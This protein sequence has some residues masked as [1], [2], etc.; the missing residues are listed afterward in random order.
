MKGEIINHPYRHY[1]QGHS[2]SYFQT[3]NLILA[4]IMLPRSL[5]WCFVE[6]ETECKAACAVHVNKIY[7]TG[8]PFPW[9]SWDFPNWEWS[10]DNLRCIALGIRPIWRINSLTLHPLLIYDIPQDSHQLSTCKPG[11]SGCLVRDLYYTKHFL[12]DHS[13]PPRGDDG[14]SF[15][16]VTDK[17]KRR[18]YCWKF[19]G[20]HFGCNCRW[21]ILCSNLSCW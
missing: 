3:W 18:I 13:H 11:C 6:N 10:K 17:W 15:M 2:S 4:R 7:F 8:V 19:L 1:S 16:Q 12:Q 14:Y 5:R 20:S 9:P 21:T